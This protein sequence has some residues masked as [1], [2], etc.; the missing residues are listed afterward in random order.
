MGSWI[1]SVWY[2]NAHRTLRKSVSHKKDF[3]WLTGTAL[4]D[5]HGVEVF[6][7]MSG[8]FARL[9]K[10]DGAGLER[11]CDYYQER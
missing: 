5:G 2:R 8:Y 1:K 11:K 6:S 3:P 7:Q 10:H 4:E 9:E